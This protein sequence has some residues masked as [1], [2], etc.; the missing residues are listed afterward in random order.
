MSSVQLTYPLF[1][2]L[3]VLLPFLW[4]FLRHMPPAPRRVFFGGTMLL[5]QKAMRSEKKKHNVWLLLL[6]LLAV[7]LMIVA[8]SQPRLFDDTV[9]STTSDTPPLLIM[10]LDW[11]SG[12]NFAAMQEQAVTW[13][14]G[15][16]A[17]VLLFSTTPT[18][19]GSV[20]PPQLMS[21]RAARRWV[22][23][24]VPRAWFNDYEEAQ[25][26]LASVSCTLA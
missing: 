18:T 8:A 19:R 22:Q 13:L 6:R 17:P 21:E 23:Q 16:G 4:R 25:S 10:D 20:L 2:S 5:Q 7:A 9:P 15:H 24:Q 11:A 26:L 14:D 3:L 1:L 12:Q